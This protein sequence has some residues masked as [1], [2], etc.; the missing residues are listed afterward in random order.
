M[1][2]IFALS[3]HGRQGSN[4]TILEIAA[5][6]LGI[7]FVYINPFDIDRD[8]HGQPVVFRA[9]DTDDLDSINK[10]IDIYKDL[11]AIKFDSYSGLALCSDKISQME[12][13]Q[14]HR[15]LMPKTV[16]T[17]RKS[18]QSVLKG[19]D[20]PVVIKKRCGYGGKGVYK[21]DDQSQF[22]HIL[23]NF[24]EDEKFII[25]NY[26]N[27]EKKTDIRV[28][29]IGG[30]CRF[31][32]RRYAKEGEFRA[33]TSQGADFEP[34]SP[35]HDLA[36]LGIKISKI[37]GMDFAAIDFIPVND[38]YYF[39]EINDTF[40]LNKNIDLARQILVFLSKTIDPKK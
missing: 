18:A 26:I 14:K 28:Y 13:A 37:Y 1:K 8:I 25:Q 20:F 40:G 3:M 12:L 22:V 2:E 5:K 29:A 36:E 24:E 32:I 19:F 6:E 10:A 27:Q 21:A 11:D 35:D 17:E 33:N 39:L 15:I 34:I 4:P 31:G 7:S 38:K 23:K 9:S 30:E 16:I